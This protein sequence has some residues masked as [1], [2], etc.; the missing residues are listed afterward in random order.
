MNS[1]TDGGF[2]QEMYL[3]RVLGFES[4]DIYQFI[5]HE[6]HSTLFDAFTG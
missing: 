4:L 5:H 3:L 6:R 1:M 2:E